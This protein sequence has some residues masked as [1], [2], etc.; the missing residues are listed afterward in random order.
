MCRESGKGKKVKENRAAARA[1][2]VDNAKSKHRENCG[3]FIKKILVYLGVMFTRHV[4]VPWGKCGDSHQD[5]FRIRR[6][7]NEHAGS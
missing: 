2:F 1:H 7:G 5:Q 3:E 6:H 4:R